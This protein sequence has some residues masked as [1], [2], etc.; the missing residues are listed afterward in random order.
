MIWYSPLHPIVK[1]NQTGMVVRPLILITND[2][3]VFSPGLRAVA[4]AV[5]S[6][7]DL[8]IAAPR[9]QQTG[10]S[11]A[12][13]AGHDGGMIEELTISIH[14]MPHRAYGIHATPALTVIHAL[15]ELAPRKP[16][17]CIS[18]INYGENIGMT[19]SASGTVG[20]ALEAAANGISALAISQEAPN[21]Q[22]GAHDYGDLD[23]TT[24]SAATRL[25][26]EKVL[27]YGLPAR[28]DALNINVPHD[29]TVH[30]EIRPTIQ[31]RQQHVYFTRLQRSDLTRP[32]SLPLKNTVDL[33][34]LEPDSDI[35]TL[36]HDRV[37][38][39]SPLTGSLSAVIGLDDLSH[40]AGSTGL[41]S[42]LT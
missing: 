11:R 40:F 16:D 10:M 9:Y 31:S 19:I 7:G 3:G 41:A 28:V 29:A 33:D 5:V 20:A 32:F 1:Q 36:L 39:V 22:H 4:E 27:R 13:H 18:G 23:W 24:A 14:D 8:L 2:D 17:L 6:L 21:V 25:I 42:A 34:T 26:A 37:I 30:T 35:Q 15:F 12:L 38:S